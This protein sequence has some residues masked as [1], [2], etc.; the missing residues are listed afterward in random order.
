MQ[1]QHDSAETDRQNHG[2]VVISS[3]EGMELCRVADYQHNRNYHKRAE[4]TPL[5]VAEVAAAMKKTIMAA[6]VQMEDAKV[7]A[8]AAAAV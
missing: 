8:P 5:M 2:L 1:L 6:G 7:G 4:R 3:S